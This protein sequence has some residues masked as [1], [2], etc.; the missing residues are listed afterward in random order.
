MQQCVLIEL[1]TAWLND[2]YSCFKNRKHFIMSASKQG[3]FT[4]KALL[5]PP[6]YLAPSLISLSPLSKNFEYAPSQ[7]SSPTQINFQQLL[8]I[9]NVYGLKIFAC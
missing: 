5:S 4:V 8:E 1:H 2:Q 7:S 3:K 6:L 9:F